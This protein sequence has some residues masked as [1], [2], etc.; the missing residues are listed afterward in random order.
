[1]TE[2]CSFFNLSVT[3][4]TS[5]FILQPFRRFI[6]VTAHSLTVPLL[7][8]RQAH[9][10]TLLSLLLRHRLFTYVTWRALHDSKHNRR[11]LL[12]MLHAQVIRA[13]TYFWNLGYLF[14]SPAWSHTNRLKINAGRFSLFTK[15][16]IACFLSWPLQLSSTLCNY[17]KPMNVLPQ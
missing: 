12:F 5:Q 11:F 17:E 4:P 6:H 15:Q 7:H 2:L 9:S 10:P 13:L 16:I 3:S 14:S 1:M 8:Q